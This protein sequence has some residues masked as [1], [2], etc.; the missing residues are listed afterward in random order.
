MAKGR[1]RGDRRDGR[2]LRDE[3]PM[4]L[5]MPYLLPNRADN[6]AVLT[7]TID[8]TALLQY[9]NDKNSGNPDF[10]YTMFHGLCAALGKTIAQRPKMNRFIQGRRL[11]ER[12]GISLSF[13]V[14]KQ[15]N[16]DSREALAIVSFDGQSQRTSMEQIYEQVRHIVQ[17]VRQADQTDGATDVMAVLT[18]LPRPLLRLVVAGLHFLDYYG[19]MPKSLSDVD[20]YYRTV[21]IS[22]LG[23][24]KLSADYHHLTNY[25]T[26]SFFVVV[27]EMHKRPFFAPDGSYSMRDAVELGLTIDERIADGAY[28]SGS[29]RLLRY[30]LAN[31]ALLDEPA[32]QPVDIPSSFGK[33][34]GAF[35]SSR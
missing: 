13:V 26:N 6:E 16:D 4:H 11:Y 19:W 5:F 28:F 29:L 30:L 20:P 18:K 33:E 34:N 10:K 27:G 35:A 24:I 14:K 15:L 31:P 22:N 8:L 2:F 21:F 25:G 12:K 32:C 7:E 9:I 17:G 23:S 1:Q 3:D